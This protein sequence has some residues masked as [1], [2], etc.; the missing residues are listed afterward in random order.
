MSDTELILRSLLAILE[1]QERVAER[2]DDAASETSCCDARCFRNL[3]ATLV[4]VDNP[5]S[6]RHPVLGRV[7][8]WKEVVGRYD[9]L[10]E[11]I[12]DRL[13]GQK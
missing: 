5:E 9:T 3:H 11:L 8:E 7:G 12:R 10:D 1:F 13:G 4:R 6:G 2:L